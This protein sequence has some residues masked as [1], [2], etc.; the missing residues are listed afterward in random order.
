MSAN[1][2]PYDEPDFK[3][4]LDNCVPLIFAVNS[5]NRGMGRKDLYPFVINN[6]V[7][8]KLAFVHGVVRGGAG[9]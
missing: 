3:R 5:L 1:F 6:G 7:R 8:E 2:N 4:I 9:M